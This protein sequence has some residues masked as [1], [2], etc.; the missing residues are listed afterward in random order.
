M[1]AV[2]GAYVQAHLEG[3]RCARGLGGLTEAGG[4]VRPRRC[5]PEKE[6]RKEG[7]EMLGVGAMRRSRPGGR[8]ESS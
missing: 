3:S 8:K 5:H 6:G 7:G 2:E 4:A 1:M